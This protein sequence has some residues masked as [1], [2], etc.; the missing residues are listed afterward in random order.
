MSKP[1]EK[2]KPKPKEEDDNDVE[3]YQP[4]FK[5]SLA[6]FDSDDGSLGDISDSSNTVPSSDSEKVSLQKP[7]ENNSVT[8]RPPSKSTSRIT[9]CDE[10][11]CQL[12]QLAMAKNMRNMTV[13]SSE[14]N[15]GAY[16]PELHVVSKSGVEQ[17][18]RKPFFSKKLAQLDAAMKLIAGKVDQCIWDEK[19]TD[20]EELQSV[21]VWLRKVD[22]KLKK[23]LEKRTECVNNKDYKAAQSAKDEYEVAVR[24]AVDISKIQKHLTPTEYSAL[25]SLRQI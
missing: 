5:N 23:L 22:A 2:P 3:I 21:L 12:C 8:R 18:K 14:V 4:K 16:D 7:A 6:S 13:V 9:R 20:A 15:N 24:S 25:L 1:A 17:P 19:Y 11:D 10:P